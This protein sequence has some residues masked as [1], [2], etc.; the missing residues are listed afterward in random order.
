MISVNI[1]PPTEEHN[2]FV[3]VLAGLFDLDRVA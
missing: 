1:G 3:N 2:S